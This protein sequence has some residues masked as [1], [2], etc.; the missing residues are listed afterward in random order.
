M[1]TIKIHVLHCGSID[2]DE[3]ASFYEKTIHPMP[4]SGIFR[5]KKHQINVPVSAYLIEHPKGLILIDTGWNTEVRTNPKKYLGWLYNISSTA[6]LPPQQAIH[7]QLHKLGYQASDI[8]Y[9]F[10][11]HLHPDHVSGL[12][13]LTNAK[14]ILT[15]SLELSDT[16]KHPLLYLPFM[17]K[18]VNVETFDFQNSEFDLFGDGSV[19]FVNTPGHTN[20][21]SSTIVQNDGKFVLLCADT[22]YAEKSWL[23]MILPGM[24]TNKK[25][26]VQS[27]KWV[28]EMSEN[29]NCIEVLA[30][31]DAN[32]KPHIIEF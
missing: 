7:E 5:S 8:D 20:G 21:M 18:D 25:K 23:H 24:M 2:L 9:L 10:L 31:H 22:G 1:N 28:K 26:A 6:H 14:R 30:N 16:K 29:P 12:K 4:Y 27:L 32:V 13:L 3:A 17:W 11:S 15:S 19:V